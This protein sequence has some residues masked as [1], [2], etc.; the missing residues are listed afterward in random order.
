MLLWP[1]WVLTLNKFLSAWRQSKLTQDLSRTM[2]HAQST[3][4]STSLKNGLTLWSVCFVRTLWVGIFSDYNYCSYDYSYPSF[5]RWNSAIVGRRRGWQSH[6]VGAQD[7]DQRSQ[8]WNR[9]ESISSAHYR[10]AAPRETWLVSISLWRNEPLKS[11]VH[12]LSVK[13][14]IVY[15]PNICIWSFKITVFCQ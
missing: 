8:V 4:Q 5:F 10:H 1:F 2:I 15:F 14:C 3:N 6:Q 9:R 7:W 13:G 12:V 11:T